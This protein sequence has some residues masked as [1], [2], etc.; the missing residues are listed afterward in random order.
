MWQ[1]GGNNLVEGSKTEGY[2]LALKDCDNVNK[3]VI[4]KAKTYQTYLHVFCFDH[5]H[6]KKHI[7][8]NSL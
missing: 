8:Q 4:L 3:H 1:P 7:E 5:S 6:T 2:N